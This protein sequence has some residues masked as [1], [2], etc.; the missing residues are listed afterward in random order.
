MTGGRL[1]RYVDGGC[2]KAVEAPRSPDSV[3]GGL[4]RSEV[5]KFVEAESETP[6][7]GKLVDG[8]ETELCSATLGAAIVGGR[9]NEGRNVVRGTEGTF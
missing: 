3:D 2:G 9:F 1:L 8:D 6:V 4:G 7:V 5:D